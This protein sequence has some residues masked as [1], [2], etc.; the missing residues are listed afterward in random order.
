[1]E[2]IFTIKVDKNGNSTWEDLAKAKK[3]AFKAGLVKG[4]ASTAVAVA[5]TVIIKS[6]FA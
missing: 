2:Y 6:L 5:V 3:D 1:M 4:T